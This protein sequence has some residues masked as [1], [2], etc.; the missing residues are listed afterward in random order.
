MKK[1]SSLLVI[2]VLTLSVFAG[3]SPSDDIDDDVK[4]PNPDSN[5]NG[6]DTGGN[7]G[8]KDDVNDMGDEL[9][10]EDDKTS[11][12][13]GVYRS[14]SKEASNGYKDYLEVTII[15]GKIDKVVFDGT[16]EAGGLKTADEMLKKTFETE[17]DT[18][19]AKFMPIYSE[20]LL[21]HQTVDKVEAIVGAEKE[22][23]SFKKLAEAAL[24]NA[25]TGETSTAIV[26]I[27]Y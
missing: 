8:D 17:F 1:L 18:Y 3:C 7:I 5:I 6:G 4:P 12:Q 20:K 10:D 24:S 14:E 19:P 25:Q 27:S 2:C 9:T 11:Y 26:D 21:Q 16:D 13:S 22:N 15:G 23:E